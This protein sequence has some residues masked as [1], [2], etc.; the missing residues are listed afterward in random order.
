[1][2]SVGR[3]EIAQARASSGELSENLAES[4]GVQF[5]LGYSGAFS[6]DAQ[7][8]NVHGWQTEPAAP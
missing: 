2:E 5:H 6:G 3:N 7:K 1:V 4:F 8:F